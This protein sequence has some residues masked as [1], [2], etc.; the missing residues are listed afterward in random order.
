MTAAGVAPRRLAAGRRI[1]GERSRFHARSSIS[2]STASS[3]AIMNPLSPTGQGDQNV[4]LSRRH[5]VRRQRVPARRLE[6]ARSAAEGLGRRALRGRRGVR[7]GDSQARG[8]PAASPSAVHAEPHRRGGSAA[9]ATGRSIEAAVEAGLPVGIHVFGYSGWPMTSSGWPSFY[10]EE[11]TEHATS[12]QALVTSHDHGG[13]V[14]ALARPED[15]A[16]RMRLRLAAG[17]RLA[18]RQALEAAEGRGAAS[19]SARRRNTSRSTSGSR[20]SRWR[21][22]R[23]PII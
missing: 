5:G 3:A 8:R 21:R 19:R 18:A 12:A 11:M 14:R 10:I 6:P 9:S 7:G 22:P 23:T 20:P 13:R 4:E 15:R 2:I 1:A 17:A 16:D